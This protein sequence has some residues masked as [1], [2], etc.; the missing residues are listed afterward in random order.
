MIITAL[1]FV[2]LIGSIYI[3][4]IKSLRS[5]DIN[6][7]DNQ[8]HLFN[9]EISGETFKT[10]G[11]FV[12]IGDTFYIN[13]YELTYI[14][15]SKV[16]NSVAFLSTESLETFRMAIKNGA[17]L[18][19]ATR[20]ELNDTI[21][22]VEESVD[23]REVAKKYLLQYSGLNEE[24]ANPNNLSQ[25]KNVDEDKP[26]AKLTTLSNVEQKDAEPKKKLKDLKKE[27]NR[28]KNTP[29]PKDI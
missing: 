6:S 17:Q 8:D 14:G 9:F 15:T 4:Y 16:D 5:T 29:K 18:Y 19:D 23:L 3:F 27:G 7:N 2:I 28:I 24:E 13:E 10:N 25:I 26:F 21:L 22:R 11:F 1:C 12:T 20:Y